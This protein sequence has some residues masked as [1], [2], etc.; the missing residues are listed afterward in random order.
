MSGLTVIVPSRGRP[1]AASKVLHAFDAT[2]LDDATRIIF[3]VDAD[4]PTLPVYSSQVVGSRRGLVC[5]VDEQPASM[6]TALNAVAR[7]LIEHRAPDAIG[8]MGDDHRPVTPG[9]DRHYLNA[10]RALPGIVY[11]N[12][13]L[14]GANL[15]TQCAISTPVVARLGHMAPPT[16]THLYVD[17][18]WLDIGRGSGCISYLPH[19]VV[20]H[21]H[22]YASKGEWDEGYRRVNDRTMYERDRAAYQAY[23]A[24]H[25]VSDI[26][27]VRTQSSAGS[28]R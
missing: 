22:P 20:E 23:M 10:L 24:E 12:D 9:W 17:N 1:L 16:L 21:L 7:D 18:Y 27:A 8:F 6:V 19:V 5:V 4:D 13:R 2:C 28:T 3:A 15:P 26:M 11:G 25:G 14:Q